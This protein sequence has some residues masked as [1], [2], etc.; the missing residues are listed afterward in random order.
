MYRLTNNNIQPD[1]CFF[2][3]YSKEMVEFACRLQQ[4]V[5]NTRTIS[6][7]AVVYAAAMLIQK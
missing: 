1:S 3:I 6:Q 4:E 2:Y 5:Y 7:K